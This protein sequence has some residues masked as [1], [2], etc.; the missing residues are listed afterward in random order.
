MASVLAAVVASLV[1][2][3]LYLAFRR[4]PEVHTYGPRASA[5]PLGQAATLIEAGDQPRV[6][7]LG[8]TWR[9][10]LSTG[11]PAVGA[12]LRVIAGDGITLVCAPVDSSAIPAL[13]AVDPPRARLLGELGRVVALLLCIGVSVIALLALT[14]SPP[15]IGLTILGL[16]APFAAALALIA[17]GSPSGDPGFTVRGLRCVIAAACGFAVFLAMTFGLATAIAPA[18]S[19]LVLA[20]LDLSLG[21]IFLAVG[22]GDG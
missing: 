4:L 12:T 6:R 14:V 16:L 19:A 18:I 8:E 11:A 3:G 21:A 1:S 10:R 20:A 17:V 22:G 13:P 15:A 9:A 7:V 5:Y 2:I